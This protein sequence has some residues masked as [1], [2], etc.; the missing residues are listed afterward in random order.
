MRATLGDTRRRGAAYTPGLDRVS[1]YWR[2]EPYGMAVGEKKFHDFT[3]SQ[4]G[5]STGTMEADNVVKIAQGTTEKTRIGRQVNIWSLHMKGRFKLLEGTDGATA[6]CMVRFVIFLDKQANGTEPAV[7]DILETD[8]W[9]SYRNLA[10]NKRFVILKDKVMAL[11][12]AAGGVG[13]TAEGGQVYKTLNY[14]KVWKKPLTIEYNSTTGAVAE[15][16][17]NNIGYFII[18]SDA[19]ITTVLGKGRVRFTD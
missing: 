13:A 11:N 17:S 3:V 16:R 12:Q 4:S 7:T 19:S 14:N 10:N 6:S 18:A 8:A 2:P 9:D 15:I 1:G 5:L